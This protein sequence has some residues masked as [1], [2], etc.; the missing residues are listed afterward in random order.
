MAVT[1]SISVSAPSADLN[2]GDMRAQCSYESGYDTSNLQARPRV[3]SF[4]PQFLVD[5]LA[6]SIT[7][8]ETLGFTFGEPWDRAASILTP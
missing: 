1:D 7:Y 6:R 2:R 4:A 3:I 8:N 5:D